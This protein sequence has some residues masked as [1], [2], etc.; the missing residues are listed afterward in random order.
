MSS[1]NNEPFNEDIPSQN[2]IFEDERKRQSLSRDLDSLFGDVSVT[3]EDTPEPATL[4]PHQH[5]PAY[6]LRW[7]SEENIF[8]TIPEWTVEPTIDSIILT[9]QKVVDPYK[10]YNVAYLWDGLYNK[11]YSVSFDQKHLVMRVSLPVYPKMKTESEVTTLQWIYRNT[12]LPVPKERI[13]K[14]VAE[15]AATSFQK[16]F[17][18]IGNLYPSRSHEPGFQPR[19]GEMLPFRT[20][21]KWTKCHLRLVSADLRLKMQE[22]SGSGHYETVNRM[23]ILVDNLRELF[24]EDNESTDEDEDVLDNGERPYEP[25]MLWH[26]NISL[27]NILV[28]ENGMLCGVIDWERVSCLPLY[29]ACQ[30]PAFLR[31]ARDRPVEPLTPYRVTR[32]Q[33]STPQDIMS[34]DSNLRQHQVTL[35]RQLLVAE[36]MDMCLGWVHI[37]NNRR[38]LR[39]YESAVQNCDNKFAYGIVEMW[40]DAMGKG[41]GC[42]ND[43]PWQLSDRL[44]P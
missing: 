36:M 21:L 42:S 25:T 12:R 44:M 37:F 7:T 41:G 5:D 43:G 10:Q 2:I 23:L 17:R 27:D 28:D 19:V 6:G 29:E 18:G 35:L 8:S 24:Y 15:F 3:Y 4:P 1:N 11:M 9:L 14:Q 22:M 33:P 39:N 26:D 38:G 32:E 16:Q 34:H 31:Q 20:A 40:V 30:F 13:V